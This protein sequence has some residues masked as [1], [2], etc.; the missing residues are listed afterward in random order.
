MHGDAR[1][2]RWQLAEP[3]RHG[4]LEEPRIVDGEQRGLGLVIDVQHA[5][6]VLLGVAGLERLHE[7]LPRDDVRVRQDAV[8]VDDA[9]RAARGLLVRELPRLVVVR[10][11]QDRE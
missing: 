7:Q 6:G 8:A 4:A 1:V 5:R 3:Y 9:A 2:A 11:A 10:L